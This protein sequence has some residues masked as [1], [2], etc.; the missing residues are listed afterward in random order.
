MPH[1]TTVFKDRPNERKK[2]TLSTSAGGTPP[3]LRTRR[4]CSLFDALATTS[5][6]CKSHLRLLRIVTPNTLWASTDSRALVSMAKADG[7]WST[8]LRKR[9]VISFHFWGLRTILFVTFEVSLSICFYRRIFNLKM[10]NFSLE[11]HQMM[12]A[13]QTFCRRMTST[14]VSDP[15]LTHSLCGWPLNFCGGGVMSDSVLVR[16]FF[17]NLWS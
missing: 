9:K 1:R 10:Q 15:L 14:K 8:T 7:R 2:W 13:H 11:N 6:M 17:P 4:I 12:N 16:I 3:H 5:L